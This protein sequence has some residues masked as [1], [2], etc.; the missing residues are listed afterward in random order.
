M[1]VCDGINYSFL[2]SLFAVYYDYRVLAPLLDQVHLMTYDFRT[3]ERSPLEA[4]YPAPLYYVHDRKSY[5]NVDATV[6]RWLEHGTDGKE[7]MP[8]L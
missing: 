5:Q 8:L 4:D 7:T 1:F 6:R 3:P 2:A